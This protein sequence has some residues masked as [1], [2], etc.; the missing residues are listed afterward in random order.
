MKELEVKNVIIGKQFEDS[1][2]YQKFLKIVKEEKVNLL[3]VEAGKR[4]KIENRIYF[5]ILWPDSKNII[6]ENVLN[7]NS[8]V[9][10]FVYADFSILFTGDVEEVAEKTIL[11]KYKNVDILKSSILKVAHHRV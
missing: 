10:K 5:D 1:E 7:N 6:S 4:V 8:L 11:N 9:C 3:V 2:N